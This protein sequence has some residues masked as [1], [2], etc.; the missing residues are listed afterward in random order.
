MPNSPRVC[1][2]PG[3]TNRE[4][5]MV[6]FF[7]FPKND[8]I[9]K[10]WVAFLKSYGYN[11]KLSANTRLCSDHFTKPDSFQNYNQRLLGLAKFLKLV[12]G[13][14]PSLPP[15]PTRD[16]PPP[17]TSVAIVGQMSLLEHAIEDPTDQIDTITIKS[18]VP[19]DPEDKVNTIY[20]QC[21]MEQSL[22]E[23][24]IGFIGAG[25]MAFGIAQGMLMS[26]EVNSENVKVS[27][28]SSNNLGRFRDMGVA[29]T[30]SNAEVVNTS[31]LVF[32][33][34]KPHLLPVVLREIADLVT[35]EHVIV[36]VAA[37]VTIATVEELLPSNAIVLRLMPN[38]PC[39]VQ[40]G[41]LL[42]TRG[43][44]ARPEHGALLRDLLAPCGL[45]EEG[46]ESWID[47]HTGLSGSG[48]S[49][50]VPVCGGVGG[51]RGE[52]GHAQC[53]CTPHRSADNPGRRQVVARLW[54]APG[55]AALGRLHPW[56]HHHLWAPRAGEGGSASR[57]HGRRGGRHREGQGAGQEVRRRENRKP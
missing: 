53:S 9:Q 30:H 26:G 38:L 3:C 10:R 35:R 5:I 1:A 56:R 12:A 6:S 7:Q 43:S 54:K 55:P 21:K 29:V 2:L 47:A 32:L 14:V 33:A 50:C 4:D 20:V 46:P 48:G 24:K 16:R 13:A 25:N 19:S 18:E 45:V 37:G 31:R 41:A 34:V 28:P 40:E 49:V 8:A 22:A 42:F 51:G 23:M 17:T 44:R 27:A 36:S 39:V 52:D 15:V 57:H 11:G